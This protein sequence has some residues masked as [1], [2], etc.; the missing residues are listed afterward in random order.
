MLQIL[1]YKFSST[2]IVNQYDWIEATIHMLLSVCLPVRRSCLS[3]YIRLWGDHYTVMFR[4]YKTDF[5]YIALKQ[6]KAG[7]RSSGT[8]ALVLIILFMKNCVQQWSLYHHYLRFSPR[9]WQDLSHPWIWN[10]VSAT[11]KVADTHFRTQGGRVYHAIPHHN[12]C[13][14]TCV[15]YKHKTFA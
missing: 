2:P 7:P 3:F 1:K 11:L 14:F 15:P 5:L 12:H 13:I 6:T 4:K 10:G 8:L 9:E